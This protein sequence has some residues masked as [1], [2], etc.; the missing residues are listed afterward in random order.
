MTQSTSPDARRRTV[1]WSMDGVAAPVVFSCRSCHSIVG[2]TFN[3]V[4]SSE[5]MNCITLSGDLASVMYRP[6][7]QLTLGVCH[8][9]QQE[10]SGG[11]K[12]WL[13]HLQEEGPGRWQV[14][15]RSSDGAAVTNLNVARPRQYLLRRVLSR[16]FGRHWPKLSN[17]CQIPRPRPVWPP[18]GRTPDGSTQN[19]R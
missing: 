6:W 9:C 7:Q 12:G 16:V 17:D 10:G 15:V 8:S 13:Y 14:R 4:W 18:T 5:E 19:S 11:R 1:W 3:F 2:D